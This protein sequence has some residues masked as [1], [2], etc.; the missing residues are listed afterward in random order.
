MENKNK[1]S[2]EELPQILSAQD[3]SDYLH[4]SR[5][6]VYELFKKPPANGG[7]PVISIGI[8]KRVRKENFIT[9]VKQ[10]EKKMA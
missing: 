5:N 3:I 4:I 2:L 6:T 1:P 9:W 7:I 8:T 10:Q